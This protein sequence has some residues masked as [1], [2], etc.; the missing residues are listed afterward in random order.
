V[1]F[2]DVHERFLIL[3]FFQVSFLGDRYVHAYMHHQFE[4]EGGSLE[5]VA[6]ARQFSSFLLLLG[7]TETG[8]TF[9]PR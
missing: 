6:R 3:N 5:L 4:E 9:V 8:T 7:R 1:G 2:F